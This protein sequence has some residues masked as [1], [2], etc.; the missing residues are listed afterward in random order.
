MREFTMFQVDAF[1]ASVFTGNPAAVLI[2]DT[3]LPEAEMQAI[4]AENNLAETAFVTPKDGGYAIRWFTPTQEAAFCGHATLAAAHIL[5]RELELT[6]PIRFSTRE[7]GDLMVTPLGNDTYQM[8]L[9][10]LAPSPLHPIPAVFETLFP[11][12][13]VSAVRNFENIFVELHSPDEV[14]TCTPDI[15]AIETLRPFGLC[16]TAPGGQRHDGTEVNFVSRYFAPAGGIPEDPVTG[17]THATLVPYWAEKLH[18]PKLR[19]FQAS[20]RGGSLECRLVGDRVIL[21]GCAALFMRATI[22]LP[23]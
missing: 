16:I 17:S 1:A 14:T 22:Y 9:P 15:A 10:A 8:D 18:T 6:D 23:D 19:A 5:T 11:K 7:V 20:P 21:T 3:W 2:L 13:W 12:G 4:A